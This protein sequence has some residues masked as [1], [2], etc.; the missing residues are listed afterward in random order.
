MKIFS[1]YLRL[2][3]FLGGALIGVQIPSFVDLYGT[4]L[5]SHLNE[6]N[7]SLSTFQKDAEKYFDG[8]IQRLIN[9]YQKKTDP[10]IVDGGN[11]IASI[12]QRN[13]QL[14]KAYN[15]FKHSLFKRYTHTLYQP[16]ETIQKETWS[17]YD[18]AIKLNFT[19]IAWALSMGFMLS[20][21][22]DAL[23]SLLRL[24]FTRIRNKPIKRSDPK[25]NSNNNSE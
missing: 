14:N 16:V 12:L 2:I 19:G 25:L 4:R 24:S 5:E 17:A 3:L 7:L 18:Y 9:H 10:I 15:D 13:Q 23:L 8:D 21:L 11:N 22:V 1:D 20:I 6:S